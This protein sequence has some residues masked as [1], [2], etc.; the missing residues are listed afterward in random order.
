MKRTILGLLITFVLGS[1]YSCQKELPTQ[2]L[3]PANAHFINAESAETI[4][5]EVFSTASSLLKQVEMKSKS[6]R[7]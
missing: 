1:L 7:C 5:Q 6:K 2:E 4:A 3:I